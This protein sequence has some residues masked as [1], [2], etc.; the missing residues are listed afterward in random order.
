MDQLTIAQA[1]ARRPLAEPRLRQGVVVAAN[2]DGTVDVQV[3]GSD[4]VIPDVPVLCP[5]RAVQGLGIWLLSDGVDIFA[6]GTMSTAGAMTE[7]ASPTGGETVDSHAR[8]A[9]D[10]ILNLLAALSLVE[11]T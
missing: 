2:G 6:L 11:V 5:P 1:F 7:I 8:T 9:I 4:V 10:A 3:P